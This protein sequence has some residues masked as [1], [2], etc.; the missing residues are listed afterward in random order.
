MITGIQIR[1]ARSALRLSIA[2][3]A[4]LAGVGVQTVMRFENADGIPPS[5]TSTLSDIQ[6][7][8][9][10]CGI[11]FIGTPDDGPGIRVRH[12]KHEL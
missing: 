3:L 2:E 5:R 10:N 4:K 1:S 8:L 12:P 7:A 11:E 6:T 9:E